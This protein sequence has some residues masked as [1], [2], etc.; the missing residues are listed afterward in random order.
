MKIT[1]YNIILPIYKDVLI[2]NEQPSLFQLIGRDTY[3]VLM[4]VIYNAK[5]IGADIKLIWNYFPYKKNEYSPYSKKDEEVNSNNELKLCIEILENFIKHRGLQ[6]DVQL[7]AFSE[8]Y[9]IKSVGKTYFLRSML[10]NKLFGD[11]S[12]AMKLCSRNYDSGYYKSIITFDCSVQKSNLLE[13]LNLFHEDKS[14][15][16]VSITDLKSSEE[17]YIFTQKKLDC[18]NNTFIFI[19]SYIENK[20]NKK[21]HISNDKEGEIASIYL[22]DGI[23]DLLITLYKCK[24][25]KLI[26]RVEI[27]K[28]EQKIEK[29]LDDITYQ[30]DQNISPS[31]IFEMSLTLSEDLISIQQSLVDKLKLFFVGKTEISQQESQNGHTIHNSSSMCEIEEVSNSINRQNKVCCRQM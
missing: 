22:V 17:N 21:N 11:I 20:S 14:K 4:D 23:V 10:E 6:E 24:D 2:D 16:T 29:F 9:S 5:K 7:V 19:N 8:A 27:A 31:G 26:T 30:C 12:G 13:K 3:N 15:N 1:L 28:Y 18:L 25:H